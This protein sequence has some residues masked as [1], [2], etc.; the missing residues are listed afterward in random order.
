VCALESD[1]KKPGKN[2]EILK[3]QST[4]ASKVKTFVNLFLHKCIFRNNNSDNFNDTRMKITNG[5]ILIVVIF[6]S[7]INA[8]SCF[9]Q[10]DK[11]KVFRD[12]AVI[13]TENRYEESPEVSYN[14]PVG[15]KKIKRM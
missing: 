10:E 11:N 15:I 14:L 6:F 4:F 3:F 1:G 8:L 7:E 13:E 2:L 12:F 5:F 9:S